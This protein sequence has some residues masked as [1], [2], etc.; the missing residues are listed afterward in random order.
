MSGRG[1][2]GVGRGWYYK[3]KYGRGGSR[4]RDSRYCGYIKATAIPRHL[5]Y[6]HTNVINEPA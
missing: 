1:G 5:G 3:Q 6:I 2:R 4:N